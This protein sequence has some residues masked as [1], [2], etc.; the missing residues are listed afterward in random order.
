MIFCRERFDR[1]DIFNTGRPGIILQVDD[2]PV[3]FCF[4]F[5]D[6][7][8]P[9]MGQNMKFIYMGIVLNCRPVRVFSQ[10]MDLNTR[11]L[12]FKT[13]DNGRS[14]DHFTERRKPYDQ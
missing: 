9:A 8:F 4:Q 10:E 3:R 5:F 1:K 7:E 14:Q 11:Y 13:P 12:F 6:Q 2:T